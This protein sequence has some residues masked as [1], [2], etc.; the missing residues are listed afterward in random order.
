[1]SHYAFHCYNSM[2][3]TGATAALTR[4]LGKPAVPPVVL[5]IGSDLVIGDSLGPVTGTLLRRLGCRKCYLYGTL[6]SPVTAKEVR[7][8][9]TFLRKTHP[10]S[11]IIAVDAAVGEESEIGLVK[12]CE[13]GL[14]PGSGANKRLGKI[15]DVSVLGIVAKRSEYALSLL[16]CIRLSTVY[17]MSDTIA[18]ALCS[19]LETLEQADPAESRCLINQNKKVVTP[20]Q[21]FS[22]EKK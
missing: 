22:F 4:L 3:E 15:G 20:V 14:R 16:N 9:E 5:C 8:A 19:Y 18:R 21:F 7:Y 6:R 11:K 1:M 10:A 12:F 13:G 2:A 17:A